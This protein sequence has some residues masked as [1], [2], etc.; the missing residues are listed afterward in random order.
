MAAT[1]TASPA[2][3]AS[4]QLSGETLVKAGGGAVTVVEVIGEVSLDSEKDKTR[5]TGVPRVS[6]ESHY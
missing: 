2:K 3:R 4:F 5:G 6:S 1:D